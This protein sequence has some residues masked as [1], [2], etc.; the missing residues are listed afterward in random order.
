MSRSHIRVKRTPHRPRDR[1]SVASR[2]A[3]VLVIVLILIF[4]TTRMRNP[5]RVKGHETATATILET[6]LALASIV[7]GGRGGYALYRIEAHV[8]Y[9]LHG[10]PQDRWISASEAERRDD[11]ELVLARHPATCL[12]YWPPGHPENARCALN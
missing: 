11:L 8:T 5:F 2:V 6:R 1:T 9:D 12:A 7:D 3:A 4:V 10:T